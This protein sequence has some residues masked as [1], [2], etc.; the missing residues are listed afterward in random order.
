MKVVCDASAIFS[1]FVGEKNFTTSRVLSEIRDFES[2]DFVESLIFSKKLFIFDPQPNFEKVVRE[3][4]KRTGDDLSSAD[5]SVIALALEMNA[6]VVSNDY[7]IQ[8]VCTFLSIKYENAFGFQISGVKEWIYVC[9]GCGKTFPARKKT[10]EFCGNRIRK[11][12]K[13]SSP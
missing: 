5:I 3:A 2:R 9:E 6:T 7:G 1:G 8:N 11:R 4:L 10:C 13:A 12:L